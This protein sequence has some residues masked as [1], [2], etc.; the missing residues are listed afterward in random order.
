MAF[1]YFPLPNRDASPTIRGFAYQV[2]VTIARWLALQPEQSLELE[3]GEDIDL[4]SRV[5]TSTGEIQKRWLEQV[6]RHEALAMTLRTPEVL[7]AIAHFCAHRANNPDPAIEL[8]YRFTTNTK[9]TRERPSPL[10]IKIP[11]I[12][13]W[14]RICSGQMQEPALTH[15]VTGI[16][17]LLCD[18]QRPAKLD[19][20]LWQ[21]LQAFLQQSTQHDFLAFMHAFEWSTRTPDSPQLRETVCQQL[22]RDGFAS[23][24][25][26]SHER[27]DRLFYYV[28]QQLCKPGKK[29]LTIAD[30]DAQL[31][32]QLSPSE[33][34]LLQSVLSQIAS[35]TEAV[36][37]LKQEQRLQHDLLTHINAQLQQLSFDFTVQASLSYT[38][39]PPD[40]EMPPLVHHHSPRKTVVE[41]LLRQLSQTTWCALYGD[42]SVGKTHL[43]I[44]LAQTLGTCRAWVSLDSRRS[45]DE[46]GTQFD[47]ALRRLIVRPVTDLRSHWYEEVI[48]TL[49]AG[50]LLVLDDL[51]LLAGDDFLSRRLLQLV[52]TCEKYGVK[53]ISTSPYPL[54]LR[55]AQT[56][57]AS[58]FLTSRC[59]MF[60]VAETSDLL[61]ASGAP[62]ALLAESQF[63][64]NLGL[65]HP[66]IIAELVE[67][68][69]TQG[70]SFDARVLTALFSG[71][72]TVEL[73]ED[74]VRRLLQT[75]EDEQS[76]NLL[77][78]LALMLHAFSLDDVRAVAEV[79]PELDRPRERMASLQGRWVS[80]DARERYLISPLIRKLGSEDLPTSTRKVCNRVLGDRL[81][82]KGQVDLVDVQLIL[83]YYLNAEEEN[84]AGMLLIRVLTDLLRA[85]NAID[86]LGILTWWASTPLPAAMPLGTRLYLRG[87]QIAV[88][89][90][91]GLDVGLLVRD[92][93]AL[94][95]R[96]T[97]D[98]AWAVIASW[99]VVKKT[100]LPIKLSPLTVFSLLPQA[101]LPGGESLADA[102]G[103][104]DMYAELLWASVLDV[105]TPEQLGMWMSALEQMPAAQCQAAFR[106]SH[107]ELGCKLVADRLMWRVQKQ[108][109]AQRQWESVETALRDLATRA[110]AIGFDLLWACAI[111][112]LMMILTEAKRPL[113]QVVA[114]AET[115]LATPSEDPRVH[116]LLQE[117]LGRQYLAAGRDQDAAQ[118]L[119]QALTLPTPAYPGT[120]LHARLCLSKAIGATNPSEAIRY[121]RETVQFAEEAPG[122]SDIGDI[123][124][125]EALGELAVAEWLVG[126]VPGAFQASD[127]AAERLFT[128]RQESV[129]WK[130]LFVLLGNVTGYIFGMITLG[131]IDGEIQQ[132]LMAPWRGMFLF[133]HSAASSRYT[134][135]SESF[136]PTQLARIAE[137]LGQYER[138][139]T[140]ASFGTDLALKTGQSMIFSTLNMLRIPS[141]LAT[142]Q[143]EEALDV[144]RETAAIT[145]VL[146]ARRRAKNTEDTADLDV[147]TELGERSGESWRRVDHV[148]VLT[149]VVPAFFQLSSLYLSDSVQA[150]LQAQTVTAKCLQIAENAADTEL[151]EAG[152]SL[153]SAIYDGELSGMKLVERSNALA[154]NESNALRYIASIGATLQPDLSLRDAFIIHITVLRSL[155]PL[156]GQLPGMYR[157]CIVPFFLSYWM[158]AF[159]KRR[160][161]FS[162]I[163]LVEEDLRQAQSLPVEQRVRAVL[164]AIALGLQI[165][166]GAV[167]GF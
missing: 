98:E 32:R 166:S 159:E 22:V 5:L 39:P 62:E 120:H 40:L 164:K 160:F 128:C 27:Y 167:Q 6:K 91:R 41:R 146:D 134:A 162:A 107:A 129:N 125:V 31:S 30:R 138:A 158:A 58:L 119:H 126:N 104:A 43:A 38:P 61:G 95:E 122:N 153:L 37:Q 71:E 33:R 108:P 154:G 151:W 50:S 115:S 92:I 97:A 100:A 145:T 85:D 11:A 70:W 111:R 59:P 86:D 12:T 148:T 65:G 88:R 44:L 19:E 42:V 140:W 133:D 112:T 46:E 89:Q 116:F 60:T 82:K 2:D 9:I 49:G 18:A 16:R 14:Q 4:V 94:S 161:H 109:E 15:A 17:T 110:A 74:T 3:Y 147:E 53:L 121:A 72:A 136:L 8:I 152:I 23:D 101:R 143:Y 47:R 84:R 139:E 48:C 56:L 63:I 78:R 75:V 113:D 52:R 144:A 87:L 142:S 34:M 155:V 79:T 131:G 135:T 141:L 68:L 24:E 106:M 69:R 130:G 28:F 127:R 54:P 83:T 66:L 76:R 124:V 20:A 96:V 1:E 10:S 132:N 105:E 102:I 73:N 118:W 114:L 90:Q 149:G 25:S 163:R 81:L 29:Q 21:Q 51:P 99:A 13:A 67:Y 93:N 123:E 165:D 7:T 55:F 137:E 35:L 57:P 157:R 26:E 36:D 80:R 64:H 156:L 150:R 45:C 117:C 103:R 77:Y